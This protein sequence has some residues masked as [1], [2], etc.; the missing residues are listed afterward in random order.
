[1]AINIPVLGTIVQI[2]FGYD[3]LNQYCQN[4]LY[5]STLSDFVGQPEAT[6][7][8]QAEEAD[9]YQPW[10][11]NVVPQL[12]SSV[13]VRKIGISAY[14][15]W[16]W[17]FAPNSVSFLKTY[18]RVIDFTL[19]GGRSD[20]G[21]ENMPPFVSIG[22]NKSPLFQSKNSRGGLRLPGMFESDQT[23]GVLDNFLVTALETAL[24]TLL[25]PVLTP[26]TGGA[27][28]AS[29]Y[30]VNRSLA[31]GYAPETVNDN[32][33]Q[34]NCFEVISFEV[35]PNVTTQNSRKFGVGI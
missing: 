24:A 33:G 17:N 9:F 11:T 8:M 22:V 5:Y 26:H 20:V 23:N 1:M 18:N 2:D 16:T 7:D 3:Y 21:E 12:P 32:V 29:W 14:K 31:L 27:N 34:T 28:D 15:Q 19:A 13:E 35:N 10:L 30:P 25:T 6:F 4:T